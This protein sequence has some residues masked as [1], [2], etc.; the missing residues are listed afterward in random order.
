ML[1]VL[2]SGKPSTLRLP[3]HG[4]RGWRYPADQGIYQ[5][6][7]YSQGWPQ[8]RTHPALQGVRCGSELLRGKIPV[9]QAVWT[10]RRTGPQLNE[11]AVFPGG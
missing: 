3:G 4:R 5:Q 7:K 2:L 8:R 9:L 1:I 11:R 10:G 6:G